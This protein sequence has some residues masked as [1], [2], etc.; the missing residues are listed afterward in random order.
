MSESIILN[1]EESGS[2]PPLILLHGLAGS[3]DWWARNVGAFGDRYRTYRIDLA[4]FGGSRKLATFH[5]D[6]AVPFLSEWMDSREIPQASFIGHSMGGLIA[7]RMAADFPGRVRRLV[8]VDA[9]FLAFDPGLSKRTTGLMR[10]TRSTTTE[11]LPMFARDVFR[12][13]PRSFFTATVELLRTDWSSILGQISAPTLVIWGENDT[14]T[15]AKIGQEI[16][17]AIP[18]AR[19]VF[20]EKAGHNPMW[21]RADQFNVEVLRFLE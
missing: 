21:D 12:A 20:L 7:A 6:E 5:L 3:L 15:P 19:L 9:A 16:V 2:G 11:F 17:R 18:N 1:Y 10:S 4:G 14:I 8:L 13:H